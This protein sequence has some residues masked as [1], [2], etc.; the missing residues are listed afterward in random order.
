VKVMV[1]K[2]LRWAGKVSGWFVRFRRRNHRKVLVVDGHVGFTGGLN[3]SD[4]YAAVEDGGNGWR[5]TQVRIVGPAAA[6][7]ERHFLGTWL[8]FKGGRFD[9]HRFRRAALGATSAKLRIISNDFGEG[10]RTIRKAY[11]H[12]ITHAK[13]RILLTHAYFLPPSRVVRA[14]TRAARHGV[15]VV[16][17]LA[18]STDVRA[19]L[20]A[21]RALYRRLLKAGVE[22]YEWEGRVLHAKTAVID[23]SWSTVG[24]ANLDPQSLRENLEINAVFIDSHFANA[25]ERM[26][27]GDLK[28][29]TEITMDTVRGYGWFERLL[30][31]LAYRVRRWL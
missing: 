20:Y 4:D 30:Q 8:R 16:V 14:L 31:W 6:D 12:A 2:P 17:I 22:V 15:R 1:F 3:I 7:L 5:D 10:R 27:E 29:C 28:S 19:V 9:E 26:F 11:V 23:N 25:V 18:A 13:R 24:S 21:A